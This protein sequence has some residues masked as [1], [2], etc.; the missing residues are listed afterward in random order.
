VV[1]SRKRKD[2]R[3]EYQPEHVQT[4]QDYEDKTNE[5]IMVIEANIDVL[6]AIVKFYESLP[7]RTDFPIANSCRDD[8]VAFSSQAND[9]IYDLNMQVARARLL[10]R[11]T[12]DRKTIVRHIS[13][14]C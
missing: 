4:V 5:C 2:G 9:M 12:A 7:G 1:G 14:L 10:V 6:K 8:V 11:I 13:R 3:I